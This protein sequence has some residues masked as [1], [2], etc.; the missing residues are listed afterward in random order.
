MF[1]PAEQTALD[2]IAHAERLLEK[3]CASHYLLQRF[4]AVYDQARREFDVSDMELMD[5]INQ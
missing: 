5:K 1:G 2:A 4:R 3:T